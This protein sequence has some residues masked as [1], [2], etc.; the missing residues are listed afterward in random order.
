M[1]P[2]PDCHMIAYS[3]NERMPNPKPYEMIRLRSLVG[4]SFD[5]FERDFGIM[6]MHVEPTS[7]LGHLRVL[8]EVTWMYLCPFEGHLGS[9]CLGEPG[10]SLGLPGGLLG[11][12]RGLF[13]HMLVILGGHMGAK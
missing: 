13:G 4:Y 3:H 9:H 5:A 12:P 2:Q 11:G 6:Q 8:L 7:F 1:Y 10:E